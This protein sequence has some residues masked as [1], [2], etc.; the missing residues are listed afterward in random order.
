MVDGR[1][2]GGK[3]GRKALKS[4]GVVWMRTEMTYQL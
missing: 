2:K 1:R 4:D 3:E